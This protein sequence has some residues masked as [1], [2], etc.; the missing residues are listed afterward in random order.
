M[1]AEMKTDSTSVFIHHMYVIKYCLNT[2]FLHKFI[3]L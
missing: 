2:G 3:K 1:K